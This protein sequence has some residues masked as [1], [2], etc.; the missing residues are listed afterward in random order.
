[1]ETPIMILAIGE[2][3]WIWI[4]LLIAT[5]A[6]GAGIGLKWRLDKTDKRVSAIEADL[7]AIKSGK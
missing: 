7:A 4:A 5:A 3:G 2:I 6:G 1:M